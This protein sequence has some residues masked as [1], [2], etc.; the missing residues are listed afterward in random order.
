MTSCTV[1]FYMAIMLHGSSR[2]VVAFPDLRPRLALLTHVLRDLDAASAVQ[3]ER[4]EPPAC[5]HGSACTLP[6]IAAACNTPAQSVT[7]DCR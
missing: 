2:M 4:A 5:E 6:G 1:R 7:V 3:V